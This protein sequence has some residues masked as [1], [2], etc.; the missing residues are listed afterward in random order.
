MQ[1]RSRFCLRYQT[2]PLIYL[3]LLS[4]CRPHIIAFTLTLPCQKPI[5]S[6]HLHLQLGIDMRLSA[7]TAYLRLIL[8]DTSLFPLSSVSPQLR[9]LIFR[10]VT[11]LPLLR[12][13]YLASLRMHQALTMFYETCIQA[14]VVNSSQVVPVKHVRIC[15]LRMKEID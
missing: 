5:L 11:G 1:N 15:L 13:E 14:Y 8:I 2:D 4:Y 6:L 9:S 7:Y 3:T 12:T 10:R